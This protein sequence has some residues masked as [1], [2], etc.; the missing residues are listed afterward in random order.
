MRTGMRRKLG[1][2]SASALMVLTLCEGSQGQN[3]AEKSAEH[4]ERLDARFAATLADLAR[5]FDQERNPEAAHFLAACAVG[6]GLN[7]PAMRLVQHSWETDLLVGKVRGGT[8]INDPHVLRNA[9][10]GYAQEYG[11][12][13]E[14]LSRDAEKGTV[15]DVSRRL[16]HECGIRR[17]IAA[18]AHEYIAATHR[19]NALRRA[20]G[21][22]ALL[23]DFEISRKLILAAWYIAETGDTDSESHSDVR[24]PLYDPFVEKTKKEV[25]I[26][27]FYA[28]KDHPQVLRSHALARQDILNPNSRRLWL[29]QWQGGRKLK[30]VTLYAIPLLPF[31]EDIPTPSER[32]A[33]QTLVKDWVD[34]EETIHLDDRAIPF[35]KYPYDGEPDAPWCFSNGKGAQEAHWNPE[36]YPFLERAGVPI[37][38][39]FYSD[40]TLSDV[41][42]VLKDPLGKTVPCRVYVSGDKKV[43]LP[44]HLPTVLVVPERQLERGTKYTIDI[45]CSLQGT[46][47]QRAWS[48]TTRMQ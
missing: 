36:E 14:A 18:S 20:M 1:E 11:K 33:R 22:R 30:S 35:A 48:F 23:W 13:V 19:F 40:A 15:N 28:V 4:I 32:Y 34:T 25:T 3:E 43:S 27:P 9:L 6:F 42:A 10:H 8:P 44:L 2:F 37:M 47:F 31:R 21:L 39:R 7:D 12:I 45:S 16:L 5:R 17:E 29:A 38:L 41:K 24:S 46:R 26:A